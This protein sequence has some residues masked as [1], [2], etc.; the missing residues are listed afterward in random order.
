MRHRIVKFL[1]LVVRALISSVFRTVVA[2]IIF[3][4]VSLI[5]M[6]YLGLP[7][8]GAQELLNKLESVAQ[9]ADILS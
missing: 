5:T 1:S 9:L 4:G 8:P 7:V 3:V 6:S 2:S